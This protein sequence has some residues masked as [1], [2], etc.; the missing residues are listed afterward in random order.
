MLREELVG[1]QGLGVQIEYSLQH[2]D[3]VLWVAVLQQEFAGAEAIFDCGAGASDAIFQKFQFSGCFAEFFHPFEGRISS[4]CL[5]ELSPTLGQCEPR[6]VGPR[7][8][9]DTFFQRVCG[10]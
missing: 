9:L 1:F 7:A 3:S 8:E 10:F 2:D 5:A 6:F 4:S